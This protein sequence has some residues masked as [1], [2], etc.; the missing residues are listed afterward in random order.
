MNT[1]QRYKEYVFSIPQSFI[2]CINYFP[3]KTAIKLPIL[4][5]KN[6]KLSSMKGAIKLDC[7]KIKFGM[8]RLGF[9]DVGIFDRKYSRSVWNDCGGIIIFKGMSK[10]IIGYGSKLSISKNAVLE[11]DENFC[12]TAAT[13]IACSKRISFGKNV[14][15]SW[16]CLIMDTDFHRIYKGDSKKPK[17]IDKDI[18]IGNNV[19]IGCRNV[20]LKGVH[21]ANNCVIAANSTITKNI[22]E[23][24]C[25]VAGNPAKIIE[26]DIKWEI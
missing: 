10:K 9:G 21:I 8:V 7:E 24:F 6:V 17:N 12:I 14:L 19:W 16:D 18:E 4:V 20:I 23:E 13:S 5:S 26:H 15:I 25:I 11:I 1:F 2:F 22:D 3:L